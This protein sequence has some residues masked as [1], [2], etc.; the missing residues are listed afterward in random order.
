MLQSWQK[1]LPAFGPRVQRYRHSFLSLFTPPLHLLQ[2]RL[3]FTATRGCWTYGSSIRHVL[4]R[5][6]ECVPTSAFSSLDCLTLFALY[7]SVLTC[8]SSK[9]VWNFVLLPALSN[10]STVQ[11]G[12]SICCWGSW[13]W[14]AVWLLRFSRLSF[15]TRVS[16]LQNTESRSLPIELDRSRICPCA[17]FS[18]FGVSY[19]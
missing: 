11:V 10:G 9:P 16:D 12:L 3:L 13:T 2:S 18:T 8:A 17:T 7:I 19:L 14:T 6:L 4:F 5:F 1:H 15:V